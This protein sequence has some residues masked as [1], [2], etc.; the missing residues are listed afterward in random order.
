MKPQ[1][2]KKVK[3]K[4]LEQAVVEQQQAK[5]K[6]L[7]QAAIEQKQPK[8]KKTIDQTT[9]DD[10]IREYNLVVKP[11]RSVPVKTKLP[12]GKKNQQD[13]DLIGIEMIEKID[14]PIRLIPQQ[15]EPQNKIKIGA[16]KF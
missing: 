14:A 3:K 8:A 13:K 1:V 7:E 11:L 6:I 5:K 9:V 12:F 16:L 4:T 15:H 10:L 2:K